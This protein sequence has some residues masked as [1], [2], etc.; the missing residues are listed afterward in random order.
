MNRQ[1]QSKT[2]LRDIRLV[3][4]SPN[5]YAELY[6]WST[7]STSAFRWRFGGATPSPER[8]SEALWAGVLCQYMVADSGGTSHGLVVCYSADHV[9]GHAYYGVQGN[10][11]RPTGM[12]ASIGMVKLLDH[13]FRSWPF[14][15]LYAELPE[16]NAA[17]FSSGLRRHAQCEGTLRDHVYFD[18]RFWDQ[19]TYSLSREDWEQHARPR[20]AALLDATSNTDD[21]LQVAGS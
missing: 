8:F 18:G 15:K 20:F 13:V 10:P 12:G 17:E 2:T 9:N 4:V 6:R 3:P 11:D 14:R 16:Y 7:D 19:S 21:R 5:H 1:P